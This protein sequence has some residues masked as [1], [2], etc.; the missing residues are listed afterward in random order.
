MDLC[1]ADLDEVVRQVLSISADG[2]TVTFTPSLPGS[3]VRTCYDRGLT[4]LG[5]PNPERK[6]PPTVFLHRD[7]S[8]TVLYGAIWGNDP[9]TYTRRDVGVK[10]TN[11]PDIIHADHPFFSE[12][13]RICLPDAGLTSPATI[14]RTWQGWGECGQVLHYAE[15]SKPALMVNVCVSAHIEHGVLA[16][17]QFELSANGCYSIMMSPTMTGRLPLRDSDRVESDCGTQYHVGKF[18][19]FGVTSYLNPLG[20]LRD[21]TEVLLCGSVILLPSFAGMYS[22]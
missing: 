2:T 8:N 5:C 6:T 21:R 13:D 11:V 15:L 1:A 17:L 22:C 18:Q 3:L 7:L 10:I 14:L 4:V 19:V 20:Q 12:G 16:V 9:E